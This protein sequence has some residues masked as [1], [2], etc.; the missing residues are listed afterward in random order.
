MVTSF[1]VI[2]PVVGTA[3]LT[4]TLDQVETYL[5]LIWRSR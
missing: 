5:P 2:S 1:E 4:I 3:V